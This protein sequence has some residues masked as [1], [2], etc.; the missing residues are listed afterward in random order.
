MPGE[1]STI[2]DYTAAEIAAMDAAT[3]QAAKAGGFKK[4]LVASPLAQ[5]VAQAEAAGINLGSS[6]PARDAQPQDGENVWGR[7]RKGDRDFTCPSGQKCR[8]RRIEIDQL[9][10]AGVL[11]QVSR[12]EGLAQ[13]LI[14]KAEGQPPTK[15]T[16]PTK[17]DFQALLD[18][19][20]V[21]VPMA[22]AE[23]KLWAD[24]DASA[25]ADAIRVS[26][27]DL[28]DRIAILNEALAGVK[29]LD[30]FRPTR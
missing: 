29:L 2:G 22:V 3:F 9:V 28:E 20:N 25:P 15:A 13:Q 24:D 1:Q 12:L 16:M 8:L 21:V 17:E 6:A 5:A 11:D 18:L 19:L 4:A 7:K 27:V 26:D 14:D 23:P 10:M 30:N